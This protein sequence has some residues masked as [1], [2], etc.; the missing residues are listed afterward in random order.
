MNDK[1]EDKNYSN[2]PVSIAELRAR[3]TD[4]PSEWTVRDALIASLREID[5]GGP[6]S[7][8]THVAICFGMLTPE[9]NSKVHV[10]SAGA[11]NSFEII[12]VV[13]ECLTMVS[14]PT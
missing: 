7:Q 6:L 14:T 5:E 2:E 9:N 11:K 1:P 10:R 8:A 3:K 12:G 13:S 4:A